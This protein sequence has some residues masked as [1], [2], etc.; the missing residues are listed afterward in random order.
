MAETAY[1]MS[2]VVTGALLV[3]VWTFVSRMENWRSYKLPNA[4]LDAHGSNLADSAGVWAAGFFLLVAVVGGGAVLAVSN[5]SLASAVGSWVA[6]AA[7]FAVLLF[8]YLIWGTYSSVRHRGLH[9]AQAAL[10]SAW[11]VGSLV[12]VAITVKLLVEG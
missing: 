7:V 4:E 3:T 12:L 10:V 5:P 2:A 8:A 9:S 1:L 11:L 6:V